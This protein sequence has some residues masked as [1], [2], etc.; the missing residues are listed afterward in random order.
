VTGAG[1]VTALVLL[2]CTAGAAAAAAWTQSWAVVRRGHFRIVAWSA[3]VLGGLTAAVGMSALP[4]GGGAARGL[5]VATAGAAAVYLVL[6]YARTDVAASWGG[7]ATGVIGC[8]ALVATA[9]LI[10][11]WPAWL[12]ALELLAGAALVGSVANGMLLGHWYLNQPGLRPWALGRLTALALGAVAATGVLGVASAGRLARA[13]TQGAVLGLAGFG[14]SFGAIFFLV[15]LTLVAFTAVVV[16]M[17]RRCVA[18]R[19]IQSA[20]GLYY[21]A[22]LTSASSEFV[23]RY[24]MVSAA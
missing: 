23:V 15:W 9:R 6:Q 14:E 5:V 16:W 3:L 12:A 22:L 17:A 18:L 11:A 19:S 10:P 7:W 4:P 1:A 2:E 24:L 21:V 8:A 13:P 20:T